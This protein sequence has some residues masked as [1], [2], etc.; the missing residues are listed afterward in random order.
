MLLRKYV[1]Q[2][3]T[4]NGR[5]ILESVGLESETIEACFRSYPLDIEEAVQAGLIKWKD[6]QGYSPTWNVLIKAMNF[7]KIARHHI[8]GLKSTLCLD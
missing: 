5:A 8:E 3:I 7:A 2:K 4:G 6:G 1:S